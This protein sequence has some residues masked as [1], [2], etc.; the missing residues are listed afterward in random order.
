MEL[1]PLLVHFLL[2]VIS[3]CNNH[4]YTLNNNIEYTKMNKKIS[5]LALVLTLVVTSCSDFLETPSKSSLSTGNFYKTPAQMDQALTGVYSCL[6]P[7]SIYYFAM[8]EI[9]SDNML[10]TTEAKANDYADCSQFNSTSLLT[11]SIVANCWADYYKLIASANA[12]LENM[13]GLSETTEDV[14]TQYEAEAR[15][16]RGFAYFDLVRFFGRVPLSTTVLSTAESFALKQSE[17]V[18]IYTQIIEDLEFATNN[19]QESSVDFQGKK[20]PER[21]SAIAAKALLGK[22][23]MQ[24]A[25]FPLYKDTKAQAE[26]MLREVLQEANALNGIPTKYWAKDIDEWNKMWIHENNNKYFLFEIQY[27]C[28]KDAGNPMTPLTRVQNSKADNYCNANLTIGPHLYIN[29]DLQDEFFQLNADVEGGEVTD[30]LD[31][32]LS[33]TINTASFYDE[34]TGEYVGGIK[35]ANNFMVKFFEHKMKRNELGF[36]DMD[37]SIV[38][39]TY[40]PQNFPLLRIEDVMLL[41]AECVGNTNEGYHCLNLIRTRAGMSTLT[42]L[43]PQQFQVAVLSERRHELLGEGQRWFDQVRLNTFVDDIKTKFINY[44]DLRDGSHSANYTVYANRVTPDMYLYPIPLSQ[45]QV[46]QGLYTQ[47]KGY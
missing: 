16:L 31:E 12:L 15:F 39:R 11:N 34:E 14:K 2:A 8:S 38:D 47:N 18:E 43:S 36:P 3:V 4:I 22:V 7:L 17:S 27:A 10:Q 29:R 26:E 37:A 44:R 28:E 13:G 35:D 24:M 9:R 23:Y 30:I 6:K 46:H 40:W 41:Y 1:I 32:R 21:V 25:G 33:G 42:G 19:L 5:I 45:I 20:H